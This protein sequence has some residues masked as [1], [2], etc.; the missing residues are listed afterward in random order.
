M[1]LVI[2]LGVLSVLLFLC[3][4][5]VVVSSMPIET[6]THNSSNLEQKH[7]ESA[8]LPAHRFR[9][10]TLLQGVI[11]AIVTVFGGRPSRRKVTGPAAI[12]LMT[13]QVLHGLACVIRP[14]TLRYFKLRTSLRLRSPV[15]RSQT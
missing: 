11:K 1:I 15:E 5:N 3:I 2:L 13:S 9:S 6:A 8:S 7:S 14:R 4:S 12:A 10:V